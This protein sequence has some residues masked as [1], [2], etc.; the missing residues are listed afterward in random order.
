MHIDMLRVRAGGVALIPA[1][2]SVG[3]MGDDEAGGSPVP[4]LRYHYCAS[5]LAVIGYYL[6]NEKQTLFYRE[7]A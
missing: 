5:L 2:V 1:S 6:T 4:P 7:T 3:G